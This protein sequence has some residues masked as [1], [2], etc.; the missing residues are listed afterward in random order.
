MCRECGNSFL[1]KVDLLGDCFAAHVA[2]L[3]RLGALG[4]GAV[5][6]QEGHVAAPF[7]ADAAAVCLFDFHDFAL[8]VAQPVGGRL[9]RLVLGSEQQ[10]LPGDGEA[11]LDVHGAGET[12]F[13]P[14]AAL[15]AGDLML[16]GF[17][18]DQRKLFVAHDALLG[19]AADHG[20]T[21]GGR[22]RF[23]RVLSTADMLG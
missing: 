2:D 5:A 14:D 20:R 4:A 3:E 12:L 21:A 23:V 17:E 18:H 16:A 22:R 15:F 10:G 8:E 19:D 7:H 13:H 9:P 1:V 11:P 6:A